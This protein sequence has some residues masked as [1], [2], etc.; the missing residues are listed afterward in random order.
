MERRK[1]NKEK[2]P[3]ETS[4]HILFRKWKEGTFAEVFGDWKWIFGYSKKYKKSIT[5]YVIVG[6]LSTSLGLLGSIAGKYLIDIITGY[7]IRR[8]PLLVVIMVGSSVLSMVAGSAINRIAAKLD[9][10]I[11]NDIQADVF[12]KIM[13]TDWMAMNRYTNGDLLNRFNADIRTVSTNAVSWLPTVILS[14]YKFAATFFVILYYDWMM[15]VI[16]LASAPFLLLISRFMLRKQREYGIKVREAG[17]D[18][19]TFEVETFYNYD[20]IKSFGIG[21]Y[22]NRKMKGWQEAY[23]DIALKYNLFSIQSNILMSV[24]GLAV[25]LLAFFYCL[26]RLWSDDI[27]YGT[28]TLF[29]QQRNSLSSAFQQSVSVVPA[30][31]NSSI[32]AHRIRE[33]MELPKEQDAG[34]H[35]ETPDWAKEGLEIRMH[36]ITFSYVEGKDVIR[37]SFF[38]AAPGELVALAGPSGEGKTTML[39]LILGLIRPQEGRVLLIRPS[40][41]ETEISAQMRGLFSYVP[42]GNTIF[43]GTVAENL[44]IVKEDATDEEIREAL[45]TACA[46]EFVEKMPRG[47]HS[48]VGEKGH[49]LSEGQAQRIAIAR[50]MLRDAPILLFDEATS[51]LDPETE[52]AVLQ[53]IQK[54]C[55]DKTCIMTTHR[56]GV[57]HLCDRVYRVTDASVEIVSG[58]EDGQIQTG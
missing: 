23:R 2:H 46:L 1:N 3:K 36:D 48:D 25:Q 57:W 15:A 58:E 31:L 51:A 33:I 30:F 37:R 13:D 16:A 53:G 50:A 21:P 19:M 54:H 55:P 56:A 44:R 7:Q 40:G 38:H 24:M 20:T 35:E 4:A 52:R 45:R 41:E 49:G 6:I 32:A 17:S 10:L 5:L 18:L 12:E 28:M 27:T 26:F 43:S 9:I 14:V 11:N 22:Y 47:I 29:L 39:R 34:M 42:Q 8:L